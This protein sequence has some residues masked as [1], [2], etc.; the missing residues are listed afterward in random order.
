MARKNAWQAVRMM[1]E[2]QHEPHSRL[3]ELT[4]KDGEEERLAGRQEDGGAKQDGGA[5]PDPPVWRN[6][7]QSQCMGVRNQNNIHVA[8]GQRP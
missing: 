7:Q 5:D 1:E 8:K 2:P 4:V 6:D 3:N